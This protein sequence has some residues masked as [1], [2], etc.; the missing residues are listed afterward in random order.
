[1]T[2]PTKGHAHGPAPLGLLRGG[3]GGTSHGPL[4]G[5]WD[6]GGWTPGPIGLLWDRDKQP[7]SQPSGAATKAAGKM[8]PMPPPAN[9]GLS[10]DVHIVTGP[11]F[12][13]P[14][15]IPSEKEVLQ[16]PNISNCYLAAMLAAHA[17]TPNG[18][19]F[20]Q[21]MVT[22]TAGNVLTDLSGIKQALSNPGAD[23]L[24][25]NRFFTVK[26]PGTVR[27][28]LP[29]HTD[30]PSG[31]VTAS[32]GALELTGGS[33]DVSDVLYTNDS[34]HNWSILYLSDPV[35]HTI[36]AAVIEKAVAV[37]MGGY[38]NFD[39]LRW[40]DADKTGIP[41]NNVWEMVT[42]SS[43]GG[44]AITPQTSPSAITDA[45]KAS[46]NVPTIAATQENIPSGSSL[47]SHH[48]LAMWGLKD[49]KLRLYDPAEAKEIFIS[50]DDFRKGGVI[51]IL[52]T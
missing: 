8:T 13:P 24:A 18:R 52:H 51:A 38:Q 43:P 1:M 17:F 28:K 15:K 26:L 9:D 40:N 6:D 33:L 25:S 10:K 16:A 11:L 5:L 50:A 48:G 23:T 36:W 35:D 47:P 20:I 14:K 32:D 31:A 27:F 46:V 37:R 2:I 44:F 45:A 42:G 30:R 39:A 41:V 12:N 22:E 21:N 7:Q 19:T 34:D 49:G 29:S 4:G 3:D